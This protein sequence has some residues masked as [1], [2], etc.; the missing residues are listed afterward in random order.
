MNRGFTI[1]SDFSLLLAS[2][3]YTHSVVES[4]GY[5]GV[6]RLQKCPAEIIQVRIPMSVG[7]TIGSLLLSPLPNRK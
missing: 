4:T 3:W 5:K 1:F 7:L 2:K 6:F